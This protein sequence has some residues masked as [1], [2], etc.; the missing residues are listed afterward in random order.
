MKETERPA[1]RVNEIFCSVQGE[2]RYTGMPAGVILELDGKKIYHCGDTCLCSEMKVIG[3]IY[4]PDIMLV[5]IGSHYTMDIE[6]V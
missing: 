3:E 2:G 1:M 5:P 6:E 4:K